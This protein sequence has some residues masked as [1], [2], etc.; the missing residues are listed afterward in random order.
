ML[1]VAVASLMP[2]AP[3][4]PQPKR[5][6]L[7]FVLVPHLQLC[8][9]RLLEMLRQRLAVLPALLALHGLLPLLL[10]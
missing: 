2:H 9:T 7:R 4:V 5:K 8:R 6:Q 3:L 1:Q 10:R